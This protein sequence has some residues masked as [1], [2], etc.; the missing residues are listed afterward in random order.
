MNKLVVALAIAAHLLP[1]SY[2]VSP[3]GALALYAGATGTRSAAWLVPVLPVVLGAMLT[4]TFDPVVMLFVCA[5]FALSTIAGS[6]FLSGERSRARYAAAI[7][8]GAVIFYLVSNF[9]M[10]LAGYYPMTATGLATCYLNGLPWLLQAAL[11]DAVFCFLLFG[12]H[13][14]IERRRPQEAAA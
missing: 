13:T 2:G 12:L 14:L 5:G 6:A 1:R 10:W 9:S 8:S 3:V 11:A 4:G 7:S